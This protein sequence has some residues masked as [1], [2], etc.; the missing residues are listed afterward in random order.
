MG[1]F[2][3]CWLWAGGEWKVE[4]KAGRRVREWRVGGG[5]VAL[6]WKSEGKRRE[7]RVESGGG[8]SGLRESWD[9]GLHVS[10]EMPYF[11]V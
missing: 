10:F 3:G 8:M 4:W 6:E 7:L 11:Q 9:R 1:R 2:V 5:L